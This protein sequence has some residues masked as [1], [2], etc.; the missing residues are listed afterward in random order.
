MGERDHFVSLEMASIGMEMVADW[1]IAAIAARLA[2][3]SRRLTAGLRGADLAVTILDARLR[4]PH[5]VSLGFPGGM[6][7]GL[8]ADLA[9]AQVFVA[10]RL[11]RLRV[12][13]HVYNDESDIDRC[14]EILGRALR[15]GGRQRALG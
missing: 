4:A 15:A 3:L 1:G 11:G 12:S 14:V 2:A 10:R 5:I 9:A 7:P 8:I 6:A 13:P